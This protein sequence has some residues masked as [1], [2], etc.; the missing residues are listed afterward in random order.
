M[1]RI[2]SFR[3]SEENIKSLKEISKQSDRTEGW[4]VNH[5]LRD[6]F[7]IKPKQEIKPTIL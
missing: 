3:I 7:Q 4:I 5:A 6:Y 2:K 1:K